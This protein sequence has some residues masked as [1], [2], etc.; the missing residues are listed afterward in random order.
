VVL[1]SGFDAEGR[2]QVLLD[3][4]VREFVQKP[5]APSELTDAVERATAVT[6]TG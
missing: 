5:F 6:A 4:G 2:A 1:V 3:E